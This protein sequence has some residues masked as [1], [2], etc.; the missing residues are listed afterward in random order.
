MKPKVLSDQQYEELLQ[1]ARTRDAAFEQLES[2][3]HFAPPRRGDLHSHLRTVEAAL[4]CAVKVS[5]W[6]IV[7][8]GIV[9]L[10]QAMARI[11]PEQVA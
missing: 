11:T 8:E 7:C 5:D 1:A 9:L 10:Q 3:H 2:A 6:Q 4:A